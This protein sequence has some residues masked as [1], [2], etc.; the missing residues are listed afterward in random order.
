ME[1]VLI[2]QTSSVPCRYNLSK[3]VVRRL[4]KEALQIVG[5]EAF[6]DRP[7]NTLSGGEKQRVAIAGALVQYPKV[8]PI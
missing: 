8:T 6:G 4:V 5:L 1:L 3:S 2:Y 7:T